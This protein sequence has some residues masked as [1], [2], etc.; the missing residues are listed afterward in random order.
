MNIKEMNVI[1]INRKIEKKTN[2][3]FL[4]NYL[5]IFQIVLS[6]EYFY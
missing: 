1:T 4:K 3:K 5:I 6:N 2:E